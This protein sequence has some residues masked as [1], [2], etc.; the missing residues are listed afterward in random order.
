MAIWVG[1][2]DVDKHHLHVNLDRAG[3]GLW[4]VWSQRPA[5]LRA[6]GLEKREDGYHEK[7][8]SALACLAHGRSATRWPDTDI[9]RD[10]NRL[11]FIFR[12][13]RSE[14]GLSH[15]TGYYPGTRT[16]PRE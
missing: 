11:D 2:R 10:F 15:W 1:H 3:P 13:M 6:R 8:E 4:R 16:K 14:M 9:R 12:C 7:T 5:N